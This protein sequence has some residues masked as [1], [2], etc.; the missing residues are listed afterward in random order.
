MKKNIY[1]DLPDD[2]LLKK[3]DLMKGVVIGFGIIFF[4]AIA[5][6]LYLFSK[7]DN[8]P[9]ATIIPIFILPVTFAPLLINLNLINKESRHRNL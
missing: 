4:V 3:R 1:Q 6:L 8:I 2:K 5:V 7:Y 9:F